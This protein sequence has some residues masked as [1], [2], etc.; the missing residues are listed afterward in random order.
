MPETEDPFFGGKAPPFAPGDAPPFTPPNPNAP[1]G[2][3]GQAPP[4][5]PGHAPPFHIEPLPPGIKMDMLPTQPDDNKPFNPSAPMG[6]IPGYPSIGFNDTPLNPPPRS[7]NID[8]YFPKNRPDIKGP[9]IITQDQARRALV[10][11]CN[12][13]CC[14]SA[15]AA[16]EM[17]VSNMLSSNAFQYCLETF[18][19]KRSTA[20]AKVPYTGQSVDG[21]HNGP[22]PMPWDIP[23][24]YGA[25]FSTEKRL[26]EVPHTACVKPCEY[27]QACGWLRCNRCQGHG[28]SMCT[29]C[30]GSGRSFGASQQQQMCMFCQGQGRRRCT[31][32]GGHGRIK[33]HMC[34]GYRSLKWFI[35]LTIDWI[36]HTQDYIL[37]RTDLPDELIRDVRGHIAFQEENVQV[38]PINH[39]PEPSINQ[40]SN[41]IIAKHR[42]AFP[43]ERLIG[44]RHTVRVIP[45]TEADGHWK[46]KK[47]RF[48]VY[49]LENRAYSDDYPQQ[50]CCGCSI[51]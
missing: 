44:Q 6:P 39:C 30:H 34:Q 4:F 40:A 33:C 16:Q 18:C 22:A 10:E 19:E 35:Q 38:F 43:N 15:S 24:T 50:C 1:A 31:T 26:I 7:D 47:F 36:N 42:T 8:Q 46:D 21:P 28:M 48:F 9:A 23:A 12:T 29:S 51:L 14:W 27:C 25:K 13:H 41:S 3:K 45:V 17:S 2:D 5:A 49:G 20:W 37:E 11:H 32:C